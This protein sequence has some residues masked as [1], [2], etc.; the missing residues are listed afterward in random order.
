MLDWIIVI[1]I[2]GVATAWSG[3]KLYR[4]I[5]GKE[6][7]CA[8]CGL[9]RSEEQLLKIGHGKNAGPTD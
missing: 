5:T 2:V 4:S 1:L 7:S 9:D 6:K 8:S 3:R